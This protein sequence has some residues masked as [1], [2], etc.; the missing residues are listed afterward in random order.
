MNGFLDIFA[1]VICILTFQPRGRPD[2]AGRRRHA[3]SRAGHEA[4]RPDG[5]A[6]RSRAVQAALSFSASISRT[7]GIT[8]VP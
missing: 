8:L 2:R 3:R 1:D 4:V 5:F 6:G 7:I